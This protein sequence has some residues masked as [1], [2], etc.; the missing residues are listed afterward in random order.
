MRESVI[1]RSMGAWRA[2]GPGPDRNC[3]IKLDEELGNS[4]DNCPACT[5]VHPYIDKY[6]SAKYLLK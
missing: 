4:C 6:S 2:Q 3:E 1:S 5:R